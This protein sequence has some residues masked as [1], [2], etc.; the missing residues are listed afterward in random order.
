[1]ETYEYSHRSS[2]SPDKEG[3]FA[4]KEKFVEPSSYAVVRRSEAGLETEVVVGY[5][6]D[7]CVGLAGALG[8][9]A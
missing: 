2:C 5:A 6:V 3:A 7:S 1:M 9:G 8:V 4:Q